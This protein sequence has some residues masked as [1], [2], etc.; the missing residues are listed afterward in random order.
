M[1]NSEALLGKCVS[2]RPSLR[3]YLKPSTHIKANLSLQ[4][5][6]GLLL[7]TG[8]SGVSEGSEAG[9]GSVSSQGTGDTGH[10]A[11]DFTLVLGPSGQI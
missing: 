11:L 5:G 1:G 6:F 3:K 7:A 8:V 2:F 4:V 9:N 10:V